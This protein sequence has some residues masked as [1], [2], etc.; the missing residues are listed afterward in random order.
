MPDCY[1]RVSSD[2]QEIGQHI[3][4]CVDEVGGPG[5]LR[6]LAW[7]GTAVH[8]WIWYRTEEEVRRYRPELK[9]CIEG[10]GH[11]VHEDAMLTDFEELGLTVEG[12]P[13]EPGTTAE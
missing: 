11:T 4:Q 10:K 2:P 8:A 5:R 13:P 7:D 3:R 12:Y 6:R 9:R 1:F